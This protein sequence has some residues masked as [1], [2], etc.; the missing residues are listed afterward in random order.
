MNVRRRFITIN[1][2]RDR[3]KA[4]AAIDRPVVSRRRPGFSL[5]ELLVVIAIIVLLIGILLVALGAVQKKARKTQT[6]AIMNAFSSACQTFQAENGK[7]PGVIPDEVINANLNAGA[8]LLSSTENALL[9]L[10]G[11]YR[12]LS[13]FDTAGGAIDSDYQN[14]VT[15]AGANLV[16]LTFGASGWR[17]AIDKSKLGEGPIVNGKQHGPYFTARKDELQRVAGQLSPADNLPDLV[18]SW[19]DPII[20]IRQ[21]RTRGPLTSF[22]ASPSPRPQFEIRG[23]ALGGGVDDYLGSTALGESSRNQVYGGGNPSGSILTAPTADKNFAQILRHPGV[24][25]SV[26]S[27]INN[28]YQGTPKGSFVLISAGADGVFFSAADGPGSGGAPIASGDLLGVTADAKA[29]EE[30]DDIVVFGGG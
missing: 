21:A 20:Y 2:L 6:L 5:T 4:H 27:S 29:I 23:A 24:S 7:Y 3:A 26:F 13:P 12:V 18:D 19:G 10:I 11:G 8:P 1:N 14:F 30:F 17:L 15:A 9:E 16:Q 28:V 25:P 22:V